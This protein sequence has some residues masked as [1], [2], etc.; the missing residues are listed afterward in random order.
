MDLN[1]LDG[2]EL[3]PI[4]FYYD[5]LEGLEHLWPALKERFRQT[6]HLRPIIFRDYD[7]Y[8]ELPGT[9]GDLYTYDAIVL[10]ALVDKGIVRSLPKTVSYE[11]VFPWIMEKAR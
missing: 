9:D 1:S 8:K 11:R 10:S 3:S 5:S 6:G 2:R 4:I 7:S